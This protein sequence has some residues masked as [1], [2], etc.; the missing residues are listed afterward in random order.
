MTWNETRTRIRRF[1]RD[2]QA[3][4]WSDA[5]LLAMYNDVQREIQ[6]KTQYLTEVKA[7]RVPPIYDFAYLQDWEWPFLE[8]TTGNYQALR[9]HQQGEIVYSYRWET[10]AVWGLVDCTET[11]DGAHFTQ[12]FEAFMVSGPGDIVPLQFPEGFHQPILVAWDKEP[13]EPLTRKEITRDDS[14]WATRAGEPF[15]YWRPDKFEDQFCLVPL[16]TVVNW[17]DAIGAETVAPADY[18]HA[19]SWEE[20]DVYISGTGENFT[21][22]D[23]INLRQYVHSWELDIG[24]GTDPAVMIGMWQFEIEPGITDQAGVVLYNGGDDISGE[25]GIVIDTGTDIL[26]DS[27]DIIRADGTVLFVYLR[28]ASP[29][30]SENDE[31]SFPSYLQKYIEYGTLERAYG[32]DTD[33]R[34]P[35]LR[36]YWAWRKEIGIRA[37]IRFKGM[38]RVDRDYRLTTKGAPG[39]RTR[40]QPRLPDAYPAVQR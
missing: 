2:P 14:S 23:T 37:I 33:G 17:D 12:P 27:G 26:D 5:V 16:P 13:I 7:V 36:D 6:I 21:H 1:L 10:Q 35:S 4:I 3:R 22:E 31:S 28:T 25:F 11:D 24:V 40:R 30:V 34:I 9:F 39:Y 20:S 8:S 29:L 38:K 15:A 32:A 18:I 19:F